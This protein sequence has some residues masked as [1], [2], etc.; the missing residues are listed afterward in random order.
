L[1]PLGQLL[2]LGFSRRPLEKPILIFHLKRGRILEVYYKYLD[3][4]LMDRCSLFDTYLGAL[5]NYSQHNSHPWKLS[6]RYDDHSPNT[7]L[8]GHICHWF[9]GAYGAYLKQINPS[10]LGLEG[11]QKALMHHDK[12]AQGLWIFFK[13]RFSVESPFQDGSF[14]TKETDLQSWIGSIACGSHHHFF[15]DFFKVLSQTKR[16]NMGQFPQPYFSF[17]L[18]PDEIVTDHSRREIFVFSPDFEGVHFRGGKIARGGLRWCDHLSNFRSEVFGLFSAQMLKNTVVV[19]VGGKGGFVLKNPEPLSKDDLGQEGRRCYQMFVQALISLTDNRNDQGIPVS[20]E[21][22]RCYDEKDPYLVVAADKGTA[23]FSDIANALSKKNHFWLDDAF[24]SGGSYGYDHKVLGITAKGAWVSACHHLEKLDLHPEK[25]SITVVGVGG[26]GGDVF[27]NGLLLSRSLRM[28][29]A[30]NHK[31]IFIDPNPDPELSFHERQ[32]LFK[33]P[34]IS[35]SDYSQDKL[36]KGGQILSRRDQEVTLTPEVLALLGLTNHHVT[37]DEVIRSILRLPCDLLWLGGIGTYVKDEQEKDDNIKDFSNDSIRICGHEVGARVVAEGA[38]LGFTQA[39]RIAY[40]KKGGAINTDYLDNSAGVDCSDHEVN[41]KIL[42]S[43][44]LKEGSLSLEERNDLLQDLTQDVLD[45]V[46]L[47]NKGQNRI[48][49]WMEEDSKDAPKSYE[50][51]EKILGLTPS[52]KESDGNH[53]PLSSLENPNRSIDGGILRP[54]LCFLLSQSKIFYG[55]LVAQA[56]E[57][58]TGLGEMFLKDYFPKDLQDRYSKALQTH[59]LGQEIATTMAVNRLVNLLGPIFFTDMAEK[60]Q[61]DLENVWFHILKASQDLLLSFE[62]VLGHANRKAFIAEIPKI[63]QAFQ[64][65]ITRTIVSG[66]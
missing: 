11:L 32:R 31:D 5:S 59:L 50:K 10:S 18:C 62:K 46:L 41:L 4:F 42:F 40:S 47:H 53:L 49:S 37:P 6:Q 58:Q 43:G 25:D 9:F 3:L 60:F 48:L 2:L 57:K 35:W 16:T 33:T 24:A 28:V 17:K 54:H 63:Q 39:G 26:M 51:L 8:Y 44:L 15:K 20:P 22:M 12:I 19:P 27:G 55:P 52:S 14:C 61:Q 29:A 38:N 64:E 34:N 56:I 65:A 13:D 23:T 45:H 30:F 7:S 36:S 1:N 66:E 21:N